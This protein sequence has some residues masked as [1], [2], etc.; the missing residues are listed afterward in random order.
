[1]IRSP[2]G[3]AGDVAI[4]LARAEE[5]AIDDATVSMGAGGAAAGPLGLLAAVLG[6][7]Q[8]RAGDDL[9][10]SEAGLLAA[11]IE[12]N[13]A[14]GRYPLLDLDAAAGSVMAELDLAVESLLGDVPEPVA[15][16]G[17]TLTGWAG[18][19][20]RELVEAWLDD[21]SLVDPL[22]GFWVRVAASP[23]LE[24]AAA[25]APVP[26]SEQWRGAACPLCGG[27][28]Q[29]SVIAEE[30]GE[31]LGG[32]PRSLVC[33][34]CATWWSFPRAVCAVCGEEDPRNLGTYF[35]EDQRWVRVDACETCHGYVKTFDL[36]D[37]GGYDVVPLVDDVATLM[38]DLW[39]GEQGLVR[40]SASFAGV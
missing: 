33:G 8:A 37:A 12:R 16:A 29:V 35:V 38:L 17:R 2:R 13:R 23:L 11:A 5:L 9:I 40:L 34:R 27:Q 14:A 19:E 26:N 20:R 30:T 3:K 6:H 4:R 25:G 36:R 32:S 1:M 31:F 28:A 21:P 24:T 18:G 22:L 15:T 7:H 39:A 10:A